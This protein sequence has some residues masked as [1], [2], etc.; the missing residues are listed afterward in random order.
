[1][2]AEVR[3]VPNPQSGLSGASTDKY[4]SPD[5]PLSLL[6]LLMNATAAAPVERYAGERWQPDAHHV[7]RVLP[8]KARSHLLGPPVTREEVGV[9]GTEGEQTPTLRQSN[10]RQSENQQ[11]E[12][13]TSDYPTTRKAT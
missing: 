13:P 6:P 3:E 1:M 8:E 11:P 10:N 5:S 4:F 12:N 2:S 9:C 7:G